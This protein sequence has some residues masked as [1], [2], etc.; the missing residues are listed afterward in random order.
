MQLQG[1]TTGGLMYS[2]TDGDGSVVVLL[3]GV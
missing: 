1:P 3:H 2:H